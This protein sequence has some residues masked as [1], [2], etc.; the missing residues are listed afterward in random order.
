VCRLLGQEEREVKYLK[1]TV[2]IAPDF[3][4]SYF[5]LARISLNKGENYE[6]AIA[7]VKKGIEL[8]P[9]PGELPFGYFLLADL[10]SRLGNS[11]LSAQYVRKGQELARSNS[12]TR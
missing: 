10:Y 12:G 4:L 8:N 3:P 5:Y 2:E 9:E 11:A 6:E 7:L 1:M